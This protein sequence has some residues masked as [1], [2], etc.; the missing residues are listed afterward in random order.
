MSKPIAVITGASR[1]IGRAIA[2]RLAKDYE[3]VAVARSGDQLGTLVREIHEAGGVCQPRVVD[4]TERRALRA[5]I[6]DVDAQVLINNAG[7]GHLKPF[8]ELGPNEWREMIDINLTA[9]YD[10]TRLLL[11]KMIARGS[12]HI[13]MIGSI[14]G[15]SAFVGG[16]GYT[17]TKHALM[18]F[19]ECLML[20]VR[21]AGVKVSIVNPGSVATT[22]STRAAGSSSWALSAADVADAVAQVLS[23]PPNVLIHRLEVRT[24]TPPRK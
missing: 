23:T 19:A 1:G 21:E 10:M 14:A 24:L 17:A 8:V 15:R 12:G 9:T 16:T 5:A 4:L 6:E 7:V 11:P 18:A 2:L 3:I 22:F 13:V 20:E